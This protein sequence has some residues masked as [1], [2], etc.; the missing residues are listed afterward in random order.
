MAYHIGVIKYYD[1]R[2]NF[3]GKIQSKVFPERQ[4]VLT[5]FDN[6]SLSGGYT[7]QRD[8]IVIFEEIDRRRVKVYNIFRAILDEAPLPWD[9]LFNYVGE[10]SCIDIENTN[11]TGD[12]SRSSV[13]VLG[14]WLQRISI[15]ETKRLIGSLSQL[16]ENNDTRITSLLNSGIK[17]HFLSQCLSEDYISHLDE[18][19]QGAFMSVLNCVFE[20]SLNALDFQTIST[21]FNQTISTVFNV[22]DGLSQ[23]Y[24]KKLV[25]CCN[26]FYNGNYN[27][28]DI[29][30]EKF[31]NLTCFKDV[32]FRIINC[33]YRFQFRLE[34]YLTRALIENDFSFVPTIAPLEEDKLSVWLDTLGP[35]YFSV[36]S[37]YLPTADNSFRKV[38]IQSAPD[39]IGTKIQLYR[40]FLD[41]QKRCF[42][43]SFRDQQSI[44]ADVFFT[45]Y[46][47]YSL[48]SELKDDQFFPEHPEYRIEPDKVVNGYPKQYADLLGAGIITSISDNNINTS[49]HRVA[50]DRY[51]QVFEILGLS[52]DRI[53]A[54]LNDNMPDSDLARMYNGQLLDELVQNLS[55]AVFDLEALK[56]EDSS[57]TIRQAAFVSESVEYRT[58]ENIKEF[59]SK[60]NNYKIIVGHNI[61]LWDKAVLESLGFSFQN[62][63]FFWDTLEM[64][65]IL[66]PF[67]KGYSLN[68]TNG[69]RHTAL[70]DSCFTQKLFWSQ[71]IRFSSEEW[72]WA[73]SIFPEDINIILKLIP[74]KQNTG[75]FEGKTQTSP[76][77]KQY[78]TVSRTISL[79]LS[80]VN[81]FKQPIII[82][83]K[84]LWKLVREKSEFCSVLY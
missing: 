5:K 13:K 16:I 46:Q 54:F 15:A 22:C 1:N 25:K 49:L 29:L 53:I 18:N 44:S 11:R 17:E 57:Y 65:M 80:A 82:A 40:Y 19:E 55:Y 52:R 79:D 42:L 34:V 78:G 36:L 76:F 9:E 37:R 31:R 62:N 71:M 67:S 3:I 20:E 43:T 81:N 23:D 26:D 32:A 7:P 47:G 56:H 83:P 74:E 4:Y 72:K 69:D 51:Q 59:F 2:R 84:S 50:Q 63:V 38:Y 73:W 10:D 58:E 24:F 70:S 45:D 8:D 14:N 68:N 33:C 61:K 27:K 41:E 75:Y 64:E 77:F 12:V 39:D 60:L 48:F 28:P 30:L 21:V 35:E 66:N 6:T